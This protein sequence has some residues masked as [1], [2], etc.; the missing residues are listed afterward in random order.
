MNSQFSK[1]VS[2]I[3]ALS[4][5][6]A[7][8]LAND[9]VGA[10][11]LL[12]GILRQGN[13]TV[14]E[15]LEK[16][17]S[18]PMRIKRTL[19][20]KM[21]VDHISSMP[22]M[23]SISLNESANN[24]LRL[25]VLEARRQH[26]KEV[27]VP[28]LML[29]IL[30]DFADNG[31]KLV[32]EEN[33]VTYNKFLGL[34]DPESLPKN[35]IGLPDDDDDDDG[36]AGNYGSS[37]ND[38]NS[39]SGTATK[40]DK[41]NSSTPVIDNFGTDLTEAAA[42]G[43]LDPVVGREREIL[44][45]MEILGRRKKNNPVLIGEPGVG[46]SAIVEGLAQMIVNKQTSPLFYNKRLVNLDMASIVAG[47]KYRGQ[48]EERLKAL[49]KE[50]ENNPDII[51]FIDEI[52]T[53]VGAGSTPGTMD[54]ANIMKPALA[55]GIIQC[56]G[57]T[58]LDEYRNSIEKDGALERRFQKVLIEPTT[59]EQTLQ[60]LT[61]IRGRYEH[62][63]HVTYTDDALQACV[64]LTDRYISDR[65]FPDKAID[66]LDEAGSHI[67]ISKSQVPKEITDKQDELKKVK[68][69]KQGAVKNQNYELAA[70]YRDMQTKLENELKE[71]NERWANGDDVEKQVI[72][73]C[74]IENVVSM[75][76]G[77][78]VQKLGGKEEIRLKGMGAELKNTVV[79]QDKAIDKVVKAIQRNRVGLKDPNHPIGV[80][81]FLGPTGVGKTFLAKKLAEF[82]FGTEDAL[83]R[84]DMSE[85]S[86]Q[87]TVSRLVGAPPGYVG[88]GEGGQL[89]EKVRRH[90]YSV[91]LL[92][93]I[94]KAHGNVFN[95]LL[96]VFDD[97][98]L[99]DGNGRT[100][101]FRNT[102]IIM[103][104]NAG[105]RQLKDFA[106]GV[107]F[108]AAG[109]GIGLASDDKDKE[110]ARSIIQKALSKQFSP[111]FLN[112]LDE[113]ITFD[114][115]DISAI[116]QIINGELNGLFLRIEGLGY[117][118][119]ITDEAKDMVAKKG[120]DVQFGARP[121]K[122][123][124]QNHIEDGL[125]EMIIN[126]DLKAG[127]TICISKKSDKDELEFNIKE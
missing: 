50:L 111:E 15:A 46:K 30:H 121:L 59:K 102:V 5:E 126:G 49:L 19:D 56:I 32:L 76:T 73:S 58:T 70:A 123:A 60:I 39:N 120:Y 74:D 125:S 54:A 62:H 47:T 81:M 18:D 25:A 27:D 122:R 40:T 72:D 104:S 20:M 24:I 116:R 67:R 94:E 43:A 34:V 91:V 4:R 119:E 107:G 11:T 45:V 55:R 113:I 12:L 10:E 13:T 82:M 17:H 22:N 61:N 69:Q 108:T 103:T 95:M 14:T 36:F 42:R 6:E 90:P 66:A 53:L 16:L 85:Y 84:I 83:I 23:E 71:M 48:F 65:Q 79:A 80:F 28:H 63:H 115:L 68:V 26:K 35:D 64:T 106:R 51:I 98:R 1:E 75:M 97:G 101:D 109:A 89:T 124:I 29:A 2:R 44:R 21:R 112:R 41:V 96:Q 118:V 100:V 87:H 38:I 77:I 78:P 8:R 127:D 117:K 110:Y 105:T 37:T 33:N 92:D 99:T 86:E 31:A 93:E 52:H 3:L 7:A 57:A 9:T 114:Q 88:Y